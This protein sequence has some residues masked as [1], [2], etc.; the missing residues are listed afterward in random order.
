MKT[1]KELTKVCHKIAKEKGFWD[2][3]RN[4]GEM[5]MLIVTEL[6]EAMEAYRTQDKDGF[7]EEVADTFIRL[8]DLCGGLKIDIENEIKK[9]MK[10]NKCRPYKHGKVC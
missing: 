6:S 8:L 3:N 10:R 4:I 9:K 1:I 5:L 7:R 2:N